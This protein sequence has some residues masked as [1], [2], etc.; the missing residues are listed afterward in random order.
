LIEY[1]LV[2]DLLED[3]MTKDF[4]G[5][6]INM[7]TNTLG[8]VFW[9]FISL[10]FLVPLVNRIGVF[11]VVIIAG[12][13]WATFLYVLPAYA[14]NMGMAIVVLAG[15]SVLVVLFFTRRRSYV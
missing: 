6:L 2:S 9:V 11:P 1:L 7:Y 8:P 13:W 12:M 5:N 15:M 10:I 14:L 4:I 3:F